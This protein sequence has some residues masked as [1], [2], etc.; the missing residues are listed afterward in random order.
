[1]SSLARWRKP[2]LSTLT[3]AVFLM[4]A[5]PAQSQTTALFIDSQPGDPVGAGARRTWTTAEADFVV[6][7]WSASHMEIRLRAPGSSSTFWELG[8][9]APSGA[10]LAPG[11]Y[12]NAA[13]VGARSSRVPGFALWRSGFASCSSDA[14][15]R[16]EVFE[17]VFNSS[18]AVTKFAADFEYHCGDA[19]PA[20]FGA[21]RYDS[22]RASLVPFDGA[23]PRYSLGIVQPAHGSVVADGISCGGGPTDC[24]EIFGA[25]RDV[26]LEA[27]PDPGYVFVGWTGDCSG[28]EVTILAVTRQK[29][30]APVACRRGSR[31]CSASAGLT[32]IPSGCSSGQRPGRSSPRTRTTSRAAGTTRTQKSVCRSRAAIAVDDSASTKSPSQARR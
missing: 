21:L 32:G 8:F 30:C 11:V 17:I 20:L 9:L 19:V 16:F 13:Y 22:S 24:S 12:D 26:L 10:P 2:A 4:C 15:G 28:A 14:T 3:F 31:S 18:G 29:A 23:Y 6:L 5:G 7:T 25:P 1:M 27:L